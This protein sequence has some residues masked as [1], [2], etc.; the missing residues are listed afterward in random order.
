MSGPTQEAKP[1]SNVYVDPTYTKKV[2]DGRAEKSV[3]Q[4]RV[5]TAP[6]NDSSL[7]KVTKNA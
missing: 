2:H 4:T 5:E 1:G 6:A 7:G 3:D